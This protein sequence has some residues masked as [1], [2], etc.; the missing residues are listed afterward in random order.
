MNEKGNENKSS[1][2]IYFIEVN[3]SKIY[4]KYDED[5]QLCTRGGKSVTILKEV[6]VD[7][8]HTASVLGFKT[9]EV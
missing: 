4:L 8:L 6:F 3:G 7:F 9:G 2:K 5:M 1:N